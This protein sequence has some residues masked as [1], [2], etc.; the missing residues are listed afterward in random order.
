MKVEQ[1]RAQGAGC[2]PVQTENC[3][4]VSDLSFSVG[5]ID[6]IVLR[7]P[8]RH[9]H[10]VPLLVRF[11][12]GAV[13]PRPIVIW[14]HGGSVS[15]NGKYRSDEWGKLLA[16]AGYVVIHP[17]RVMPDVVTPY[18]PECTING[19]TDPV[20]CAGW[21]AQLRLG[22]QNTAFI[23]AHLDDIE[24]AAPALAG[25]LD[26]SIIAVGGHSAGTT[27]V[28]IAAGAWQQFTVI[29]YEEPVPEPVAFFA[30]GP[31][32]PEYAGFRSGFQSKDG[33]AGW[34]E[35]SWAGIDRPYMFVSGV[36]DETNEPPEARTAAFLTSVGA[37]NKFL[38]WDPQPFAVH[39]TM[40]IN[41]CDDSPEQANHCRWIASVGLA[42]FD[43]YVRGRSRAHMWLESSAFEMLT[44]GEIE[45]F[46]R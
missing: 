9:G 33:D 38:V 28:H 26:H 34:P 43:A 19:V 41:T 11:P 17:S 15:E 14:H 3:A 12:R 39:E 16:S 10:R 13:G 6:G 42:Y 5:E 37:G 4:Y 35:H 29:R 36:G 23:I 25:R 30:T 22:P 46:R 21:I 24:A 45:L 44:G 31:Q 1:R 27:S 20:E 32:G 18:L 40:N 7:D 8:N 2:G